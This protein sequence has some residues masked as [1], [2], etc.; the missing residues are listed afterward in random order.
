MKTPE[1]KASEK[2]SSDARLESPAGQQDQRL[3]YTSPVRAP[4]TPALSLIPPS[5]AETVD[6]PLQECCKS[7]LRPPLLAKQEREP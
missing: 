4:Y 6:M 1:G 7:G 2:A 3:F 5:C